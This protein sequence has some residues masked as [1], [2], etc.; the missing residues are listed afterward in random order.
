ME[1]AAGGNHLGRDLVLYTLA[2]AA[3][4]AAITVV[5]AVVKV[6]LLVALAI[7]LVA[8][9]P[10]S[11]LLFRG[12]NQRVTTGLAERNKVRYDER[13]R[14]RAQLRGDDNPADQRKPD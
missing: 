12:L 11:L 5:L 8:G 10:L 6:P 4:V 14:L 7:A 3:L 13:E 1:Q 2:R 9:F